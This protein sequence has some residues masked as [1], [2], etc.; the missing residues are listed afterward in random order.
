[1]KRCSAGTT[2]G[3]KEGGNGQQRQS[4]VARIRR[5]FNYGK[6]VQRRHKQRARK[7]NVVV[8]VSN[9]TTAVARDWKGVQ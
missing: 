5:G 8:M 3:A 7:E 1:M 9:G 2:A 4:A 6:M